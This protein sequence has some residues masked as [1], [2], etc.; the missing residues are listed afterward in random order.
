MQILIRKNTC[1]HAG[2][3][4]IGFAL[5]ILF[6]VTCKTGIISYQFLE[7]LREAQVSWTAFGGD[8]KSKSQ[9]S[10]ESKIPTLSTRLSCLFFTH[11]YVSSLFFLNMVLALNVSFLPFCGQTEQTPVVQSI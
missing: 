10:P 11:L 8:G 2:L 1:F 4:G 5:S 6:I 3:I 9:E 7:K